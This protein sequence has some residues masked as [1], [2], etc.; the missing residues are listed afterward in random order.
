MFTRSN[1]KFK[2]LLMSLIDIKIIRTY[3]DVHVIQSLMMIS[4]T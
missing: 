3:D 4:G 1:E 2:Y